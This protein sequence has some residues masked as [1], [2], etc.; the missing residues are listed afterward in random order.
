[1]NDIRHKASKTFSTN[2]RKYLKDKLNQLKTNSKN[3]DTQGLYGDINEYE[4]G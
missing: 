3:K 1:M 4:T 2:R